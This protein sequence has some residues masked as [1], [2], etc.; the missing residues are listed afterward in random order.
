MLVMSRGAATDLSATLDIRSI[1]KGA[2]DSMEAVMT[3]IGR[4]AAAA[5]R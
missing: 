3:V 1:G 2:F 4:V 5:S